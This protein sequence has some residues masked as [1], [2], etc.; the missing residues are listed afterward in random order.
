MGDAYENDIFS[1][2]YKDR[3]LPDD[4]FTKEAGLF[5]EDK[6]V[7][8]RKDPVMI[9]DQ[10]SSFFMKMNYENDSVEMGPR[11][12]EDFKYVIEHDIANVEPVFKW[13]LKFMKGSMAPFPY[14]EPA[15]PIFP[16]AALKVTKYFAVQKNMMIKGFALGNPSYS[17]IQN[18]SPYGPLYSRSCKTQYD[19]DM[20]EC[21]DNDKIFFA[22]NDI[23]NSPSTRTVSMQF[24]PFHP[25][26]IPL[27]KKLFQKD[28]VFSGFYEYNGRELKF[29]YDLTDNRYR[30]H[31]DVWLSLM[32]GGVDPLVECYDLVGTY[33][34]RQDISGTEADKSFIDEKCTFRDSINSVPSSI[35]PV[36]LE[37]FISDVI[38]PKDYSVIGPWNNRITLGVS[39][40]FFVPYSTV[41]YESKNVLN[42]SIDTPY[43]D[44]SRL[45][46]FTEKV[47]SVIKFCFKCLGNKL[48]GDFRKCDC[49]SKTSRLTY[50][51]ALK[52]SK[53]LPFFFRDYGDYI[54]AFFSHKNG[55]IFFRLIEERVPGFPTNGKESIVYAFRLIPLMLFMS[56]K[57]KKNLQDYI[58]L[59]AYR[60]VL[61]DS[62]HVDVQY[63]R[64]DIIEIEQSAM[65]ALC[66][67]NANYCL[68]I[69]NVNERDLNFIK[70][71]SQREGYFFRL[72]ENRDVF[73]RG[74][75]FLMMSIRS[76][77]KHY[78]IEARWLEDYGLEDND[79]R[80]KK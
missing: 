61:G 33:D 45:V 13:Y 24:N 40:H 16:P 50:D 52:K 48:S 6:L 32:H 31:S 79:Q 64:E 17:E 73:I 7:F 1:S 12:A 67:E 42:K 21:G 68:I 41:R 58:Q 80:K 59:N 2:E 43:V 39:D 55:N 69:K 57:D 47:I 72:E 22:Y 18:L 71:H 54:S 20:S 36:F 23:K 65:D 10:I 28:K 9:G 27:I 66:A 3:E 76:E 25:R 63:Q 46:T 77:L 35:E 74:E 62:S 60:H 11:E 78:D 51:R 30:I 26:S 15:K 56:I 38:P 49:E 5:A 70:I 14:F 34:F 53:N 29:E 44:I 37:P 4:F 8:C 19:M 75:S